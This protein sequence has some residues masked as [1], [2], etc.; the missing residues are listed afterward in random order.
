M[1]LQ[2]PKNQKAIH[3]MSFDFYAAM[4]N[5]LSL[6]VAALLATG[7]GTTRII[8]LPNAAPIP[9][10]G[11]KVTVGV[12]FIIDESEKVEGHGYMGFSYIDQ[13]S[14]EK[15]SVGYGVGGDGS[16][17]FAFALTTNMFSTWQRR[18]PGAEIEYTVGRMGRIIYPDGRHISY[19]YTWGEV[20]DHNLF[21][22]RVKSFSVDQ[23]GV[24]KTND[25]FAQRGVLGEPRGPLYL[26]RRGILNHE[27]EIL[28][29]G[30][31]HNIFL[32]YTQGYDAKGVC[33]MLVSTNGGSVYSFR[34]IVGMPKHVRTRDSNEGPNEPFA[35]LLST[36]E[37]LCMMRT[38]IGDGIRSSPMLE[39][40]SKDRGKTWR[41]RTSSLRGVFPSLLEMSNGILV[42][43]YG[44]P[45]NK[46]SFSTNQGKFW[47]KTVSLSPGHQLTTGYLD[48][49]EVSPGKLFVTYDMRNYKEG[50]F[51]KAPK[52]PSRNVLMGVFVDV[53][54]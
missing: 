9:F 22:N 15:I 7:C 29:V 41:H 4:I 51:S 44:R 12:P 11:P 18:L 38:G 54:P 46:L 36:G 35:I 5:R 14:D 25:A 50:F 16:G 34:S 2:N 53:E 1:Q 23:Y 28:Q 52:K 43:G 20:G 10:V 37:I 6:L 42:C 33:F 13:L 21:C 26:A 49:V 39:A 24:T 30:F 27:G 3:L 45:G 8:E 19:G 17:Q 40:R 47:S 48:M 32:E 31:G